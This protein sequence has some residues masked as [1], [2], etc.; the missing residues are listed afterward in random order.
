MNKSI[1][2]DLSGS[3]KYTIVHN[4]IE[5]DFEHSN[6]KI[7]LKKGVN[8]L[9]VKTDKSCQGSYTQEVF[10]SE[11]VEFYPNPTKDNVNLYLSLIHI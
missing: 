8:F 6:P 3:D 11:E 5:K 2:F 9:K 1:S 7:T 4:G 10:I